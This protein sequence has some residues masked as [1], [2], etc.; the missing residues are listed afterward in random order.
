MSGVRT[1]LM[2]QAYTRQTQTS[3][4]HKDR[5]KISPDK[6]SRIQHKTANLGPEVPQTIYLSEKL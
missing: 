3:M 2:F 4:T 6:S 5:H 1:A